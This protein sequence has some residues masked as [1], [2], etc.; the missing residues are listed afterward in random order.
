MMAA[1]DQHLFRQTIEKEIE[2]LIVLLDNIAGDCDL[3]DDDREVEEASGYGD[4]EG[5]ILE[6]RGEPSLGWNIS[7]NQD[8]P[9]RHF[10]ATMHSDLELDN[11]DLEG[12][13]GWPEHLDQVAGGFGFGNEGEESS[14]GWNLQGDLGDR[15]AADIGLE[16]DD[17][18]QEPNG[19]EGDY[20]RGVDAC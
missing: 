3:E 10:A 15:R 16:L 11:C 14:L 5:M 8:N 12:E 2:R 9:D 1:N 13:L 17:S 4:L 6:E 20:T 7:L 19:D 18:D